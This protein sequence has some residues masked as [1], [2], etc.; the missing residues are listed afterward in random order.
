[1]KM[2]FK[3]AAEISPV[4]V[5]EEWFETSFRTTVGEDT[6]VLEERKEGFKKKLRSTL[7]L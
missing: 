7:C 1:M 6:C 3:V 2:R 4:G 5:D